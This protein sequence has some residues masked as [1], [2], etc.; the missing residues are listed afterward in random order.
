MRCLSLFSGGL[1]SMI[2]VS[3]MRDQD[4]EVI[5]L[6]MDTGFGSSEDNVEIL[7]RRAKI[8]GATL[9]IVDI[10]EQFVKDILFDPKY[11]YG[12]QFNPCIDCHGNM[13]KIALSLLEKYDARFIVTGEVKGQRPMSQRADAMRSV[14]KLAMDDNHLILRPLC[15]KSLKETTPEINGWVDRKMLWGL[16]GRNR[17]M[18]LTYASD[19]GWEDYQSPGG[20]C[21]L[22]EEGYTRK[23][24]D[25]I[26]HDN[27]EASD[28]EILKVG[29]HFR[30]LYGAKLIISRNK[31]ENDR[32]EKIN[33]QR[34]MKLK[35]E[36]IPGPIGF[37]D[38]DAIGGDKKMAASL[39]LTYTKWGVEK[40]GSVMIGDEKISAF[41]FESKDMAKEFLV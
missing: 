16:V 25:F 23:I 1:D 17:D 14:E 35:V 39:M 40:E 24:Q 18:Q 13:F 5:A 31:D 4:I 2:A 36:D 19:R 37:L 38:K 11:G 15:A 28:I 41:A 33:S 20:G 21:L 7:R 26:S 3:L 30:L 12:K 22:T 34:Y 32:M 29:R 6:Y 10:K 27:F 8:A 9:E